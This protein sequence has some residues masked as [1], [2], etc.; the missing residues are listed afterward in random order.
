MRVVSL[1]EKLK[2]KIIHLN[3][4]KKNEND[5]ISCINDLELFSNNKL[6]VLVACSD[7]IPHF[8]V[9]LIRHTGTN[10]YS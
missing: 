10:E 3:I 5:I 6:F 1:G 9:F 4:H 7:D 8:S 2:T